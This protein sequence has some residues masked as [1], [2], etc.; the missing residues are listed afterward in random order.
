[1]VFYEVRILIVIREH[2]HILATRSNVP[3]GMDRAVKRSW[4]SASP[5]AGKVGNKERMT[6]CA[7][8]V[9]VWKSIA[10]FL[11]PS[12]RNTNDKYIIFVIKKPSITLI[13]GSL[14]FN[15]VKSY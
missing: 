14:Y 10:G 5:P 4:V 3:F 8:L 15:I 12:T 11:L 6:A 9:S 7:E 1:M 13:L 2:V